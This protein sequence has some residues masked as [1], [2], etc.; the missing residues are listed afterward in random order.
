MGDLS[1]HF[2]R[3]EFKCKCGQCGRDTVDT[4][5]LVVLEGLRQHFNQKVAINSGTRCEGHN[6][7]VG[8]SDNSQH[9]WGKAADIV[10]ENTC[11]SEVAAYLDYTYPDKYGIG[12]YPGRTHIDV[13]DFKARWG[14]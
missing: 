2:S 1:P 14:E 9:L 7:T 11:E 3:W 13:R 6:E 4:E 5:L 8:G 12:R 10:V